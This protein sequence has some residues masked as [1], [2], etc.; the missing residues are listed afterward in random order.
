LA[1]FQ[2]LTKILYDFP[3]FLGEQPPIGEEGQFMVVA[4]LLSVL[5]TLNILT[6]AA[7]GRLVVE[8]RS[9]RDEFLGAVQLFLRVGSELEGKVQSAMQCLVS[10]DA[11]LDVI[12]NPEETRQCVR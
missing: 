5:I 6:L 12:Q 1:C 3:P 10:K 8:S 11:Q 9:F 7:I 2:S 4:I